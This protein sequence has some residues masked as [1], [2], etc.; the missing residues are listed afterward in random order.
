MAMSNWDKVIFD[1]SGRPMTGKPDRSPLRVRPEIYK[2]WVY[3]SDENSSPN[4]PFLWPVVLSLKAGEIA[5]QDWVII[6]KRG[7]QDGIYVA[8]YTTSP[9]DFGRKGFVGCGVYAYDEAGARIGAR[10]S[11]IAF[12]REWAV[13][14]DVVGSMGF[15]K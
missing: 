7:P 11:S 13:G 14:E 2:N 10:P 9:G 6:A 5:Y 12:L 1:L 15:V 8:A 3:V 4:G